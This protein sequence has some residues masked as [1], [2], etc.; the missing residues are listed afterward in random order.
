[1][2]CSLNL[3]A[4]QPSPVLT[5]QADFDRVVAY[6]QRLGADCRLKTGPLFDHVDTLSVVRDLD[7]IRAA[8]GEEKLTYYGVS[9]GTLIGQ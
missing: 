7:A 8:V 3:L 5:S 9:Y 1:M 6:N 4:Q 2:V